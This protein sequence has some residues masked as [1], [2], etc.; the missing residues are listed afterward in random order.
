MSYDNG[1]ARAQREYENRMPPEDD[2]YIEKLMDEDGLSY[3]EAQERLDALEEDHAERLAEQLQDMPNDWD[4]GG[5][6]D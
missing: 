4:R 1:F 5:P 2:P 3:E 6:W